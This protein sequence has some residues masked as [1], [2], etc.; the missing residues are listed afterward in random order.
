[1]LYGNCRMLWNTH[2]EFFIRRIETEFLAITAG[3]NLSWLV[4]LVI[5]LH[6]VT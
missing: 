2:L 6:I 5:G 1:M 4:G 3:K